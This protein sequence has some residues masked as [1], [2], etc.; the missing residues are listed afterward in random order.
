MLEVKQVT[1]NSFT[2][3]SVSLLPHPLP[4]PPEQCSLEFFT[5]KKK[6]HWLSCQFISFYRTD[7]PIHCISGF[8]QHHVHWCALIQTQTLRRRF[9]CRLLVWGVIPGSPSREVKGW[10]KVAREESSC[11][12]QLLLV[13]AATLSCWGT[14]Q[15][16]RRLGPCDP[17][18][19]CH[20][21]SAASMALRPWAGG[22]C[23]DSVLR[24][25]WPWVQGREGGLCSHLLRTFFFFSH[26]FISLC[27]VLVVT[28]RI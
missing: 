12:F 7:L 15:G 19:P 6:N 16:V 1:C 8:K 5:L 20:A 11:V 27:W 3:P 23:S 26:L 21:R 13:V 17:P 14:W 22:V 28:H 9:E 10:G 24:V 2:D 25:S 18:A 4:H